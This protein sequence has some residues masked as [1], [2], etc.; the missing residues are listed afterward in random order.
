MPALYAS[1]M[2]SALHPGG[3]VGRDSELALLHGLL[4]EAARGR[5]HAVLIEGEPG[6]GKSVLM[7]SVTAQAPAAGCEVFWGRG[8]ELGQ[9]LPLLPFIDSLRV[10]QPSGSARRAAILQLLRGEIATDRGSDVPSALAEQ[11]LAL[12]TE[13]CAVR[14]TIIVIDDLQWADPSSIALWG[15]LARIT[16]QMPLLLVGLM[17]PVPLRDDL[18]ALRRAVGDSDRLQLTALSS[19]ESAQ[20][21]EALAGGKPDKDLLELADGAAGNPLYITELVAALARG[22][23]LTISNSGTAQMSGGPA[24]NSLAAAIA[25]RLGFVTGHVRDMLR[26]AALLGVDFCVAD[27]ST[28]LGR[29]MSDLLPA[30]DEACAAGVLVECGNGL[31]FRHPLIRE[32]LYEEMPAAVRAAWHREAGR[33]LAV[34]GAAID[35]VARQLLRATD[36]SNN[37][38]SALVD[39][40]MQDWLV[41]TADTL[42]GQAPGVAAELLAQAVSAEPHGT[43][44]R[45]W[46]ASRLADAYFRIGDRTRAE[47][48]ANQELGS[49]TQPDI[50]V[51]LHWTLAQCRTLAGL[52]AES[53]AAL[54]GAL[55]APGITA[56]QRAN[57]LVLAARTY[58]NLGEIERSG[59]AAYRALTEA[60]KAD[61]SWATGWALLVMAV[62]T[63]VQGH[64]NDALPLYDRALV[65]T[66]GNSSLTDLRLLLQINKAVT[67]G[68]LDQYAE[69]LN[70]ARQARNLADQVGTTFRLSQA[71]GA[72]GQL[73]FETGQWDDA[74]AEISI[75]PENLKEPAAACNERA[76]TA[77]IYFHRGETLAAKCNLEG[78]APFTEL[79]GHR[80]IGPLSLA[81]SL[82]HE[83][84]G[85]LSESLSV[86]VTEIANSSEDL[87]EVE[88][89]LADTVRLAMLADEKDIARSFAERASAIAEGSPIP[90]RQANALYCRGMIDHDP[91]KL[92]AAAARYED[93]SRPLLQA[94]A[95]EAAA[96]E[97]VDSGDR[98]QGKDAFSRAVEVYES[99][100]AT[101]DIQ[102]L[103]A[104]FRGYGIRRGPRSKHRQA[105]SGWDSLTPMERKI[106]GFVEEGLSNPDIAARL[107]LSRRTVGTHVSHILK[108]L[109][110]NS[111]T[112]I[113]RE[114]ALRSLAAR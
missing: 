61:D 98:I 77:L 93:A 28:V 10:R 20:L 114:A 21:V 109:G 43:S 108:K 87:E 27:L 58:F 14:P 73:L 36:G 65:A 86:L 47:Q 4:R 22:D 70:A 41:Q 95:L 51:D 80:L 60:S 74:L 94:K 15:R 68:N 42:V 34:S 50:I 113:A 38:D 30:I 69:A 90:H 17:R 24:P 25:D 107:T 89:L 44:R 46:L 49:A 64:M 99:L 57:L 18:L 92:M 88:G 85:S 104:L 76:I 2:A 78:V 16:T 67:L 40:W 82:H 59:E 32:A 11:L 111:R 19:L 3:L 81:R 12:V 33:A 55:Q 62:V 103:L 6:I 9:E 35:R 101:A 45:G 72:L 53:L 79:I 54:D 91:H 75:V 110:V 102:R 31:G 66:Q 71:H 29:S 96:V 1:F 23:R 7:R 84:A 8:D 39:D 5:G 48:V 112:D 13:Q 52:S 26:A 37:S 83:Y 105:Q 100:G 56:K 63:T 106:A 97:F